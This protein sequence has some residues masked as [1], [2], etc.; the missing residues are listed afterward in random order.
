MTNVVDEKTSVVLDEIDVKVESL[1]NEL[2]DLRDKLRC[3]YIQKRETIKTLIFTQL[4]IS[5]FIYI[6]QFLFF[7]FQPFDCNT[8][9]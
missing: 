8:E 1:K 9:C 3:E 5:L 4:T 6:Y 2:D 7:D